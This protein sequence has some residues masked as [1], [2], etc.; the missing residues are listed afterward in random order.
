MGLA[1]VK[2]RQGVNGTSDIYSIQIGRRGLAQDAQ[3]AAEGDLILTV[4]LFEFLG[5]IIGSFHALNDFMLLTDKAEHLLADIDH[6]IIMQLGGVADFFLV[7]IGTVGA[8]Q[9]LQEK[10][11]VTVTIGP[12]LNDGVM[13]ADE[14]VQNADIILFRATADA[15]QRLVDFEPNG[16]HT[17]HVLNQFRHVRTP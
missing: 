1:A 5:V 4:F 10:L 6:V 3:A 7:Y 11:A 14:V 9:V 17:P 15:D 2:L 8:T 12:G 13:F 16:R